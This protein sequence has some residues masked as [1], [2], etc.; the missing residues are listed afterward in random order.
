M[1]LDFIIIVLFLLVI[2][3]PVGGRKGMSQD[4]NMNQQLTTSQGQPSMHLLMM[5][6]F[7]I[8][9]VESS[10]CNSRVLRKYVHSQHARIS[11]FLSLCMHPCSKDCGSRNS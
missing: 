5:K 8:A 2:I 9:V 11:P 3:N 1:T 6:H 10:Q 4:V 7:R